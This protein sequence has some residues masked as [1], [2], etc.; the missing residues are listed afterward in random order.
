MTEAGHRWKLARLYDC[1]APDCLGSGHMAG[2]YSNKGWQTEARLV[3]NWTSAA[4][5]YK[6]KTTRLSRAV[7]PQ[8]LLPL[9]DN[10]AEKYRLFVQRVY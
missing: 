5:S 3:S 1:Y 8:Q 4:R 7:V 2:L 10:H 9:S 6:G